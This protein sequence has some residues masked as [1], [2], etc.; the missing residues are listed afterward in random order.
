MDSN[1]I[2]NEVPEQAAADGHSKNESSVTD[3]VQS[4]WDELREL[5]HAHFRLAAL[6]AQQ[7]GNSLVVIIVAGIMIVVLLSVAWLGFLAAVILALD[8]YEILTDHIL[9]ILLTVVLNLLLALVLWG[10][11]RSKGYY[12]R[13]PAT[14]RTLRSMSS[15]PRNSEES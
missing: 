13:F 7:A 2:K 9:L 6:E 3:D 1:A 12:L 5:S 14:F 11:I 4:L 8:R 10:V 15:A